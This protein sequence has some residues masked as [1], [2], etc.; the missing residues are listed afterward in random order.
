MTIGSD[1]KTHSNTSNRESSEV[2]TV[3]EGIKFRRVETAPLAFDL[4]VAERLGFE[5]PRNIRNLI[6]RYKTS[7]G[8][9]CF[10]VKQNAGERG[11]PAIEY[12]LTE[13]QVMFLVTKSETPRAVD[14]TKEMIRIFLLVKNGNAP[15]VATG[16]SE[17]RV[18][19]MIAAAFGPLAAAISA[20]ANKLGLDS[21]PFIG[22]AAAQEHI[23]RPLRQYA[24]MRA[25]SLDIPPEAKRQRA[26]LRTCA[27]K[28]LRKAVGFDLNAR[29][30]WK[31]LPQAKLALAI[32]TVQSMI[33]EA[34]RELAMQGKAETSTDSLPLM[35]YARRLTN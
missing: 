6:K 1:K 21:G 8:D 11:R 35:A 25:W 18:G 4:D 10:T 16:V 7:L 17:S 12:W 13:E 14:L 15:A 34:R 31:R 30:A 2:L 19:E 29:A 23:L 27:D 20:L 5:R 24:E 32:E 26:A 9:I 3:V 33:Y 28:R 22:E